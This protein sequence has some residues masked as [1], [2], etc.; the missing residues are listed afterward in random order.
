VTISL[1]TGTTSLS[2][3][4]IRVHRAASSKAVTSLP[5]NPVRMVRVLRKYPYK[6]VIEVVKPKKKRP[7]GGDGDSGSDE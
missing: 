2:G 5:R 7:S 6:L 1:A 3:E 4:I